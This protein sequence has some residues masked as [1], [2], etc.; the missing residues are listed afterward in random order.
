M[1]K[2]WV[3]LQVWRASRQLD[4]AMAALAPGDS[5]YATYW[6]SESYIKRLEASKRDLYVEIQKLA[7]AGHFHAIAPRVKEFD[8][9]EA[10]LRR[11]HG[12]RRAA[13]L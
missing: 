7:V 9:I 10:E 1:R 4:R 11:G 8:T 13:W 3:R 2:F 5:I 6:G 12:V